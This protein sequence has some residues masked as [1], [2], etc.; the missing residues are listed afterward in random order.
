MVGS[1]EGIFVSLSC[2]LDIY[3]GISSAYLYLIL[4]SV[5]LFLPHIDVMLF[6]PM[7]IIQLC[8]VS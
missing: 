5:E 8:R 4:L 1:S 2:Q 7:F 6:R 3:Q